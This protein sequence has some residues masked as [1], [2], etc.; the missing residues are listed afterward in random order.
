MDT[1]IYLYSELIQHVSCHIVNML[2]VTQCL[3]QDVFEEASWYKHRH[4]LIDLG[5]VNQYT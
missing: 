4:N 5:D 3:C 1:V 2:H